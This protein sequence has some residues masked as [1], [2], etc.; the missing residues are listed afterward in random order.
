MLEAGGNR[1][2]EALPGGAADQASDYSS[3]GSPTRG[4]SIDSNSEVSL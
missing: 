2:R 4:P 3:K 1:T